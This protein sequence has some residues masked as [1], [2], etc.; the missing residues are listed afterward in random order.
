MDPAEEIWPCVLLQLAQQ[1]QRQHAEHLLP[2]F[3]YYT[4]KYTR[5]DNETICLYFCI[6]STFAYYYAQYLRR[7]KFSSHSIQPT[8][9]SLFLRRIWNMNYLCN[10]LLNL[11]KKLFN[12]HRQ[13]Y[14]D[15]VTHYC[16]SMKRCANKMI[17][18]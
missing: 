5:C 15:L 17:F 9:F 8:V 1:P 18:I 12:T 11:K 2:I 7:F 14:C 6:I 3:Y 4:V 16:A 13:N 10:I